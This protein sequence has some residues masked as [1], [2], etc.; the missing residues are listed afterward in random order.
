MSKNFGDQ[1]RDAIQDAISTQDYSSMKSIVEQS[2]D[3]A[4]K[5]IKT[6]LAQAGQRNEANRAEY[7]R[8]QNEHFAHINKQRQEIMT[9]Q[10]RYL[11]VGGF[12]ASGYL[13]AILGGMASIAL[14]TAT[15]FN[16]IGASMLGAGAIAGSIVSG[17]LCAGGIALC[18][19]GIKRVGF[20]TRFEAYRRIIG[21]RSFCSLRELEANTG[22][23]ETLVL[24]DLRKMIGKGLFRQGH[25]D[26]QTTTLM[27]TDEAYQQYRDAMRAK[28]ER[29]KQEQLLRVLGDE[30]KQPLTPEA[31]AMIERG[32]AFIIKIRAS[33]DD[34]PGE[35]VSQKIAQIELVLQSIFERAEEHPE[36]IGDLEQLMDYYLPVTI[37]LLDAYKDLDEQPIQSETILSSKKEI[38]DTL[39]TLNVAFGRLLDSIFRDTAWDVSTDISVLHTVLAQEGLVENPFERSQEE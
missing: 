35:V 21:T 8:R 6:G 19:L 7:I 13:M 34:I 2:I 10:N 33:N 28:T 27:V 1:I 36:V 20:T 17:L 23:S 38:E 9:M 16:V 31:K 15:V 22:E 24:K 5:S 11:S 29:D 39:D 37:K 3:A 18:M 4:A 32:Q 30:Q 12:K 14:G 26:A 25:I